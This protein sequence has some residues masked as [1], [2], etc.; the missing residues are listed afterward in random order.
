MSQPSATIPARTIG[1][2]I[3]DKESTFAVLDAAGEWVEEGKFLTT[4]EGTIDALEERGPC[5]VIL[6]SSTHSSWMASTISSLGHEVIVANPRRL[7]LISKSKKKTDRNDARTL[8]KVGRLDRELLSPVWVRPM[9][10]LAIRSLLRARKQLVNMRTSLINLVRSEAKVQGVR[11]PECSSRVFAK[12]VTDQLPDLLRPGLAPALQVHQNLTDHIDAYDKEIERLCKVDFPETQVLRQV[13][14]V[15]ALVALTF[16]TSIV[17]PRRFKDSRS[18]GAFA[19]LAP[20][21][22][23]S[24]QSDPTLRITKEGDRELRTLLVTA[25]T[26]VMRRSSPDSALKRAGMRIAGRGQPRDRA[27]GRVAVAR[28]LAVLLHRLWLTGEV[29]EPLR[30]VDATT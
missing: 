28:K 1:I 3:S 2:D 6:E 26:Y 25:A 16:V 19:G 23:Q 5:R 7:A 22:F 11:L 8:A 18:V 29:Y 9:S 12:R 4:L 27:R 13:A 24:G 30:G 20:A 15:G 14:G 17:D 21:V 10:H